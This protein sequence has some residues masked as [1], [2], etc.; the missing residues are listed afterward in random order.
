MPVIRNCSKVDWIA[1]RRG[2]DQRWRKVRINYSADRSYLEVIMR[3]AA[4]Q[5]EGIITPISPQAFLTDG[6]QLRVR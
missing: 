2:H 1:H 4:A 6:K 3:A 5:H